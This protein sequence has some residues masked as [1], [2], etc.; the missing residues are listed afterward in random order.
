MQDVI[1]LVWEKAKAEDKIC[2]ELSI[3]MMEYWST[4][5]KW[6]EIQHH[7]KEIEGIVSHDICSLILK[8]PYLELDFRWDVYLYLKANHI[9]SQQD[10]ENAFD[11]KEPSRLEILLMDYQHHGHSLNEKVMQSLQPLFAHNP[12]VKDL[13]E[14]QYAFEHCN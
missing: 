7:F 8:S 11:Q 13:V 12:Q 3:G 5:H 4:H 9:P 14:M 2:H 6:T 10:F 1:P